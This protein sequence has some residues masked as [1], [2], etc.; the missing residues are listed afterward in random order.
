[1]VVWLASLPQ[2]PLIDNY[3]EARPKNF[4]ENQTSVGPPLRRPRSTSAPSSVSMAFIVSRDQKVA[5]DNFYDTTLAGG[6]LSFAALDF[7]KASSTRYVYQ[8]RDEPSYSPIGT[9]HFQV[10]IGLWRL[11][12]A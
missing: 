6:T 7:S 3:Q 5:L 4:I 2:F 9:E 12:A 10:S 1:M 8:F 11:R